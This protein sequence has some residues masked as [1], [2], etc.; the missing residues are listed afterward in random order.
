MAGHL[1][2]DEA[3]NFCEWRGKR[4]LTRQELIRYG[5]TEM[6]DDLAPPLVSG[7]TYLYPTGGSPTGANCLHACGAVN[8][9]PTDKRDF[10]D[11]LTRGYGRALVGTTKAGVNR[12]FDM[13]ANVWEW[14]SLDDGQSAAIMGGSWWY[15]TAQMKAD[16]NETKPRNMAAVH[17]G[18]RF[19]GG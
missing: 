15:G 18:F 5:Y 8:G 17:I 4:F 11:Y 12:L 2:F 13:S 3:E 9:N 10:S 14:A 7:R 1:T 19:I 16:H 6:R